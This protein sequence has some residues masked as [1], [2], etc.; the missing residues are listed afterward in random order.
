MVFRTW[1]CVVAL[2]SWSGLGAACAE[3]TAGGEVETVTGALT[4]AAVGAI[5][6]CGTK[7]GVDCA[8]GTYCRHHD[9]VCGDSSIGWCAPV[10]EMCTMQYAPVCG[11]DGQTY[12]NEC[13]M[14][15]AAVSAGTPAPPAGG[16]FVPLPSS[17]GVQVLQGTGTARAHRPSC[18]S[19]SSRRS[20]TAAPAAA[21]VACPPG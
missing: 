1:V 8:D 13:V 9:G 21:C 15:G 19:S 4:T 16:R 11:C 5:Q 14:M 12:G 7:K 17:A 2:V 6:L 18:F 10:S 20:I 3:S